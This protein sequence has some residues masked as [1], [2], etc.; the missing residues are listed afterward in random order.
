MRSAAGPVGPN[1]ATACSSASPWPGATSSGSIS[2]S[3]ARRIGRWSDLPGGSTVLVVVTHL[4]HVPDE[5][6]RDGQ[7]AALIEWLADGPGSDAVI[8]MGDFNAAPAEPTCD[9]MR[10]A[11]FRSAFA[12]ANGQEPAVTWPSGLQAPA[13]DTDGEPRCLDYIW[14]RGAVRANEARLAFDRPA[15]DDPTLYPSDHLG[16]AAHL[17]VG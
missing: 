17:E 7:A 3:S 8:A 6:A 2:G 14:M 5:A 11:G 16:I 10:A 1:T 15:A 12:E 13:T 9:R 4:H